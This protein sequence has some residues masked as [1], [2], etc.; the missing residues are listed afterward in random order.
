[1]WWPRLGLQLVDDGVAPGHNFLGTGHEGVIPGRERIFDVAAQNRRP[2]P[3]IN[4]YAGFVGK[5][6]V[7][8]PADAI[9]AARDDERVF[10]IDG[11]YDIHLG[12][13]AF[14]LVVVAHAK[15]S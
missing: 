14:A 7:D 12:G 3:A 6:R 4:G 10:G 5:W 13:Q 9:V 11:M 1:M 15:S 8:R 2:Y